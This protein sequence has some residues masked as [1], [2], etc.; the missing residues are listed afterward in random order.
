MEEPKILCARQETCPLLRGAVE[1]GLVAERK[2]RELDRE[3]SAIKANAEVAKVNVSASAVATDP[4]SA[5][6][7]R[8]MNELFASAVACRKA[9]GEYFKLR[10]QDN[11]IA[12]KKAEK[13]LDDALA[14]CR[15]HGK[16]PK[17]TQATLQGI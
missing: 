2:V 13:R 4:A 3:L 12:S 9:Q 1:R 10:T 7:R 11:L 16:K 17:P 15:E 14:A 8:L 6:V 5:D